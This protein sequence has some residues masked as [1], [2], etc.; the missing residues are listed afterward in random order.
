MDV[1]NAILWVVENAPDDV[2]EALEAEMHRLEVVS[3]EALK[4]RDVAE[5]AYADEH[6][7]CAKLQRDFTL[8]RHDAERKGMLDHRIVNFISL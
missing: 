7:A 8:V 6:V 2:R 3:A 4:A 1:S 5:A